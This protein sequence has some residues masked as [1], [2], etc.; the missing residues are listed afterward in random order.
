MDPNRKGLN[1]TFTE[2]K[3]DINEI[4]LRKTQLRFLINKR[5]SDRLII[6]KASGKKL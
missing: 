6:N 2:S 4:E 1:G 5:S 3:E